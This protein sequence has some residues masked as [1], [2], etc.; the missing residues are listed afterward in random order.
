MNMVGN[1]APL[2]NAKNLQ[3]IY[4]N[5]ISITILN[6][7]LTGEIQVQIKFDDIDVDNDTRWC[8]DTIIL[9]PIT[10]PSGYS[11][12]ILSGKTITL[13]QGITATRM[14]NP[15]IINNKEVFA[16]P[17]VMQCLPNTFVHLDIGSTMILDNIST[18]ELQ[19]LSKI[20]V[21]DKA[22]L[23]VRNSSTLHLLANS[24]IQVKSGGKLILEDK[25]FLRQ[26]NNSRVVIEDGGILEYHK[27][28]FIY[29]KDRKSVV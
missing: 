23:I 22:S 1:D 20:V 19:N 6:Q 12:N 27:N 26:E 28:A 29:L 21:E 24:I 7:A 18:V 5:G 15:K 14:D 25:S 11:L 10:T 4:I 8:A 3:K 13:D 2:A 17:T 16:S 9:N